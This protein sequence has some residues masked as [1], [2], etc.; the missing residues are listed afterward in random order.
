MSE[1]YSA[2]DGTVIKRRSPIIVTSGGEWVGVLVVI[3]LAITAIIVIY[4]VLRPRLR[5]SSSYEPV[6][7]PNLA[8]NCPT[9]KAPIN[10]AYTIED[11]SKPSFDASWSPVFIPNTTGALIL[12]YN[13]YVSKTPGI[14]NKNTKLAGFTPIPQSRI[15]AFE[16]GK[17]KFNT[18]YYYRVA[19]VDTCGEGAL[20]S[21]ELIVN[22]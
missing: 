4:V 8:V 6:Q 21:E 18:T 20:S 17:L 3:I 10:L 1:T 11:V 22:T 9:S 7:P 14:T 15:I 13:V 12:G 5:R 19:T 16:E 2:I